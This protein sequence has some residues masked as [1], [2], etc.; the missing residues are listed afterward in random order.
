MVDAVDLIAAGLKA[1]GSDDPV[2]LRDAIEKI[3]GFV[4]MQGIFNFSPTDH[5]GTVLS[6]MMV[7][8]PKDGKWTLLLK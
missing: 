2:K 7:I 4:G 6:D 3:R 5:H 1:T 8:T